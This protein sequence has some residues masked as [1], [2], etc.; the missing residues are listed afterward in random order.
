MP[1]KNKNKCNIG[2]MT[3]EGIFPLI[4]LKSSEICE[5]YL[6]KGLELIDNIRNSIGR[7]ATFRVGCKL[8]DFQYILT[9]IC[10]FS[11]ITQNN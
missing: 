1:L 3:G 9:D 2:I 10:G 7:E 6:G 8:D 5:P 11:H 4:E